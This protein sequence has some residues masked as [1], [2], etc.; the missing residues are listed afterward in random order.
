[1]IGR[2]RSFSE[3]FGPRCVTDAR[4]GALRQRIPRQRNRGGVRERRYAKLDM[5]KHG[6]VN[7]KQP[8][9]A[10]TSCILH[11]V[12]FYA[13]TLYP[14][15]RDQHGTRMLRH[16]E[17][18]AFDPVRAQDV[19]PPH[20]RPLRRLRRAGGLPSPRFRL[21]V[22]LLPAYT[23]QTK[24]PPISIGSRPG[25]LQAPWANDSSPIGPLIS[26]HHP[27]R[28]TPC[29]SESRMMVCL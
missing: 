29:I 26:T 15:T 27:T 21:I 1:M 19:W 9:Q 13:R 4:A 10:T 8:Y 22:P 23:G 24:S 7:L 11:G 2:A 14:I 3:A 16:A 17:H 5:E 25:R 18:I 12:L 28:P 20:P 6:H